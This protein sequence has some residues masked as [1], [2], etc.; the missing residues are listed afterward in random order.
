MGRFNKEMKIDMSPSL[1]EIWR[2][3]V[4]RGA[5]VASY[6]FALAESLIELANVGKTFVTIEDLSVPFSSAICR[7]IKVAEKQITSSTPG[8]FLSACMDYNQGLIDKDKL[9]DITIKHA[10][11]D[12]IDRF[13]TVNR[14]QMPK[15]FYVD[16]RNTKN[17]LTLTDELLILQEG[18]QFQNLPNELEARWR[19]VETAWELKIA[20]HLLEVEYDDDLEFLN[21]NILDD[22]TFGRKSITSCRDALNGYQKG[23]CFYCLQKISI[24]SSSNYMAEVDHFFPH[25][26]MKHKIGYN[27]DGIWNLVLSCENCNRGSN[28]KSSKIPIR[29]Y[30]IYLADRNNWLINSHHPL[31]ETIINQTGSTM[32]K[33]NAFLNSVFN[34]SIKIFPGSKWQP[35]TT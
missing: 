32:Q 20:P 17:G 30:L 6:K 14:A 21:I 8:K 26:L 23:K 1:N 31:R 27:L 29:K 2:S 33:R 22:K 11:N 13:H 16:D 10:F 34:E 28:G 18:F 24:H 12:V 4:L 25:S 5:N 35:E 19:L 7:H 3:I 15:L 9:L